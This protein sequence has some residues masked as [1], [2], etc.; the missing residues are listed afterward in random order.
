MALLSPGPTAFRLQC[1]HPWPSLALSPGRGPFVCSNHEG[2]RITLCR[3]SG[4]P[5]LSWLQME[6]SLFL[7]KVNARAQSFKVLLYTSYGLDVVTA[8]LGTVAVIPRCAPQPFPTSS[9]PRTGVPGSIQVF[10]GLHRC[11]M[12]QPPSHFHFPCTWPHFPTS[13]PLFMLV[14][15]QCPPPLVPPHLKDPITES[16]PLL[17]E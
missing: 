8:L 12:P 2:Q 14:P 3:A 5:E 4:T 15:R 16:F 13:V 1:P 11:R 17:P 10:Q 7:V 9:R 6:C